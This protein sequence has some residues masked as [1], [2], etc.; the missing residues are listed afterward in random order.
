M[1]E[2]QYINALNDMRKLTE[3]R[4]LY[5]VSEIRARDNEWL[6]EEMMEFGEQVN[7]QYHSLLEAEM[8]EKNQYQEIVAIARMGWAELKLIVDKVEELCQE[9]PKVYS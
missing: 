2:T 6:L 3:A 1:D 9:N 8:V 7:I 5:F 4:V